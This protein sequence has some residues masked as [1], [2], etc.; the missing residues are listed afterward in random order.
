M[1]DERGSNCRDSQ[2]YCKTLCIVGWVII[3][4]IMAASNNEQ[5]E[6]LQTLLCIMKICISIKNLHIVTINNSNLQFIFTE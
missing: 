3:L 2:N 6:Y 1:R 4:I 5:V